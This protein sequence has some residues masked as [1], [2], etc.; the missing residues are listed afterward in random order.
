[1]IE[2]NRVTWYS[3]LIAVIVFVGTFVIAFDL[4]V[5]W[6]QIQVQNA[7]QASWDASQDAGAGAHCGGF[8]KD[9]PTCAAGYHCQLD[10]SRPDIG[11]TCVPDTSTSTP[12][13]GGVS[14]A[15]MI[16]AWAAGMTIV[17]SND[18]GATIR[19]QKNE[20]F[21]VE[22]GTSLDWTISF[23]PVGS[24]THVPN[25]V[26]TGGFQGVYEAVQAGTTTMTAVGKP[27]C[28]AGQMC[29]QFI[30]HTTVTFVVG[31]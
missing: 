31:S 23:R 10:T 27:I 7:L 12:S 6:E 5:Q 1:M 26:D 22:L 3:K 14:G 29:P 19:L 25:S 9:A 2:W 11:G 18:Q 16:P 20:R 30:F 8:I 17:R 15:P 13:S 4:G 21:A 28:T 24:I